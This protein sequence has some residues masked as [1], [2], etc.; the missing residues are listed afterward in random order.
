MIKILFFI[1]N[2]DG[3]GAE[4]VLRNLVNNMDQAE[5]DIT[6]QTLWPCDAKRFLTEGIK[7]KSVYA[8]TS[9]FSVLKMRIEAT[10]GL[11]YVRHIKGDYDI[12]AA[13]LE[14]GSTKIMAQSTNS[15]AL[16]LAWVH[17][18]LQKAMSDAK[19]FAEKTKGQ[20]DTFDKVVCVSENVRDSF[21][22][23]FGDNHT[24]EIVYNTVDDGEIRAKAKMPLPE[25]VSK[26]KK[27]IVSLGRLTAQKDYGRML[28]VHKQLIDDGF[29]YDLWILGKGP[30]RKMLEEYI[31]RNNLGD[32]VRLMGFQSNPY[33][34]LREADLLVCSSQYEGFSTFVTEG[35]ILGKPIV[36]TDCTGM[37]ELLGDSEYGLVT[38]NEE[39]ALVEGLRKLLADDALLMDFADKASIRGKSFSTKKLVC[40]TEK[41]FVDSLNYKKYNWSN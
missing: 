18:D 20:Y 36:T 39:K 19:A 37:K 23:L 1:E 14:C 29:D 12:E 35:L 13:Y 40:D 38:E 4:K 32:S 3:G 26:K 41:F 33:P 25:D 28:R 21:I 8:D 22:E 31:A 10:L 15:K 27:T 16:K 17:C 2:M 7:Y 6:V 5:F 24:V 11:T 30:D 9:R 34:F